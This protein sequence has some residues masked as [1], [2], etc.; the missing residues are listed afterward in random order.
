MLIETSDFE[1][2]SLGIIEQDVYDIEVENNHNFFGNDILV[3]NSNYLCFDELI[4]K[5]GLNFNSNQ[6]FLDW[7]YKFISDVLDPFYEKILGIF[8]EK[9]GVPQLIKFKREKIASSMLILEGKK[10]YAL[11]VLDNEGEVYKEP[12]IKVTGIEVVRTS[13]PLFCRNELKEALSLIF[14]TKD[15]ETLLNFIKQTKKQF[16]KQKIEDISFPRGVSDYKKYAKPI[17][18]YLKNGIIYPKHIPIAN[19]ASINYNYIVT[20]Y[21]LNN[22]LIDNGSKIKFIYIKPDNLL[23]QNIIGYIG[24]YPEKFKELF[25]IDYRLQFQLSFQNVIQRFFDVLDWGRD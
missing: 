18:K 5:L 15:K 7:A 16:N 6:E 3:H 21:S 2:E 8:A 12:K 24:N 4:Q 22:E 9:Y 10:K 17:N 23:N 20:K 25:E 13:T 14:K 11:E 1:I 19:R